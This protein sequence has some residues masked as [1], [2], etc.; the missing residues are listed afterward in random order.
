M[1]SWEINVPLGGAHRNRIWSEAAPASPCLP[2]PLHQRQ[3]LEAER[4][5]PRP[6]RRF[7]TPREWRQLWGWRGGGHLHLWALASDPL[8]RLDA[9]G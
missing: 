2:R 8:G 1:L 4:T 5:F 9:G 6:S 7:S 3:V